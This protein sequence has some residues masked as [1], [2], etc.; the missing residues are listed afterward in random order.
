[1]STTSPTSKQPLTKKTLLAYGVSDLPV[2]LATMPMMLYLNFFYASDYGLD[3]ID[4]GNM[5]LF[6]RVFDLVTDPLVGYLSDHTKTR[7]GRRK[8]WM[9]ASLPFLVIGIYKVMIPGEEADLYYLFGWLMVLWLGWTMLMIP[10]Y[11]WGAELSSDYDERTR[12]AGWRAGLGS[13]GQLFAIAFPVIFGLPVVVAMGFGLDGF[14]DILKVTAYAAMVLIPLCVLITVMGVKEVP[15]VKAPA[16]QL[17]DG[18]K[19]MVKNGSFRWLLITFMISSLGLAVMMPMNAFY[20]TAVLEVP[21]MMVP[22]VMFFGT[23]AGLA[24]LPFWMWMSRRYGKH[25]AWVGG[26]LFVMAFSPMYL[27]LGPGDF[28]IMVP[29]AVISAFGTGSFMALPNAM[30]AD[31]IDIDTARTGENRAAM[32]FSAWSL[33]TKGASSLGASLGLWALAWVGFDAKLGAGNTQAALD[34][35]K[36]VYVFLPAAIFLLATVVIWKYPI[37]KERQTRLRAAID[38][39]EERR[40]AFVAAVGE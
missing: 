3:L 2:M 9:V 17:M 24:G 8:P 21:Q 10:Y 1:M 4:L 29:F 25:R 37:N 22:I 5:M 14:G 38:R 18:L 16:M 34:G 11:A 7:W 13:V 40:A 19:V 26:F 23:F 31:V 30:K 39:R 32:F 20:V 6:A 12:V 27:F 36:Y 33:A 35:L 15:N 28:W